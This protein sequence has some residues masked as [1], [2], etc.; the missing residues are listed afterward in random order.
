VRV[1]IA[2]GKIAFDGYRRTRGLP[3]KF[4]HGAE[5]PADHGVNLLASYHPSRQNTN[6]GRLTREMFDSVFGRARRILGEP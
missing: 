1:V 5:F 2:L 6:T 4:G 3:G